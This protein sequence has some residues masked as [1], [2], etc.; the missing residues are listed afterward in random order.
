MAAAKDR[1]AKSLPILQESVLG[2]SSAEKSQGEM[3]PPT[4]QK[5]LG[6]VATDTEVEAYAFILEQLREVGWRVKNPSRHAEGQ[7]WTQNQCFAEPALKAAFGLLRPENL[8]KLSENQ[9]WVI[10]AKRTHAQLDQAIG[11]AEEDYAELINAGG[12]FT[13]PLITGVAGNAEAGY[14]VR[15][16]LLVG[17]AYETVTINGR[18]ATG[19]LSPDVVAQLLAAGDPEIADVPIDETLFLKSAERI[20]RTLHMGG[21]NK[22]D[23][24]KVMAALLLALLEDRIPKVLIADINSR[25][26]AV[27]KQHEKS[28][29]YPFVQITP[30]TNT[31]NHFKFRRAII[32]TIQELN[33]LSIKSAM[34]SGA[35]VLGKFYEVFLKYGNG[36]K[37]IGI[38]LTPRHV[39]RFAVDAVGVSANDLVFDPACGTGGFLV[40]ALDHVRQKASGTPLDRFKKHNLFGI[41]Q[42]SYVAALAIVNMI[43]RG[44]GKNNIVEANSLSKFLTRATVDGA[45]SAKFIANPPNAGDQPITRVLMNPPFALKAS[46]EQEFRFI[47]A[48]LESTADGGLLFAI[49][50]MS[51][52]VEEGEG[53]VWRR[54]RL[55]AHHTLLSVISFPEELFYPVAIQTVGV[56]VKRGTPHDPDQ[57]VFW[58][59]IEDDGFRKSKGKRLPTRSESTDLT[60]TLPALQRFLIDPTSPVTA[61]PRFI[62]A[63]PIDYGDPILE[64]VPEAYVDSLVPDTDGLMARLDNQVRED[65]SALVEVDLRRAPGGGR[66]IIDAARATDGLR[67]GRVPKPHPN[68][69]NFRLGSLFDLKAGDY[70][71]MGQVPIGKTPIATC[72]DNGNGIMGVYDISKDHVYRDGLT[73]AFNGRPLTTKIHP[74]PFAAKDDVAVAIPNRELS[75]ETLLFIQAALNA[76]RWRFSYYRK[77]FYRK[78]GRLSVALP[79]LADGELH[80]EYMERA[81]RAQ[82]YW[83]FLAPRFAEWSPTG[84][85]A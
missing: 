37:E 56:I 45:A 2:H 26:L 5:A 47:D 10:E 48:A 51:V 85:S 41:E 7:V 44:D 63:R 3:T 19:L 28:E 6:P 8:V 25:A 22:N 1:S 11:E 60:K 14:E 52:M 79:V 20:N 64:L 61:I 31:D 73:I 70:H 39:T 62:K 53:A 23:R 12:V 66:S 46:D 71:S 30:P 78:L 17:D 36:A 38:V 15:T 55:L 21:I 27:L 43:F 4:R 65:V 24:A 74:Y 29:F 75:P 16:K 9:V 77:C 35:D 34:N 83:W 58:A 33:N 50:P 82:P 40:A 32:Q 13:A 59:R 69:A 84:P 49:V 57:S 81:I 42:E 68:F 54:E 18:A 80:I 67:Q 72:A 76:E